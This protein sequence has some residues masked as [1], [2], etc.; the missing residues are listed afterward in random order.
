[1]RTKLIPQLLFSLSYCTF[2]VDVQLFLRLSKTSFNFDH[3]PDMLFCFYKF[4]GW[5]RKGQESSLKTF[6]SLY[7]KTTSTT[8]WPGPWWL[9]AKKW[10]R[11][12][13]V[14]AP[15]PIVPLIV[16]CVFQLWKSMCVVLSIMCPIKTKFLLSLCWIITQ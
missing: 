6:K 5:R 1:M 9:L 16:H 7:S 14:T 3:T 4:R 12:S 15:F 8:S 11:G 13:V 2:W 10:E